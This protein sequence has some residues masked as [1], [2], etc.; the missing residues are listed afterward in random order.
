MEKLKQLL[1]KKEARRKELANKGKT[2]ESVAELRSI[3]SELDDLNTEIE[4][5]RSAIA[6]G[7]N[8]A[9]ETRSENPQ[10]PIGATTI[11]GIYGAEQRNSPENAEAEKRQ[12]EEEAAEKRGQDLYERRA[13]MVSSDPLI[14]PHHD[15]ATIN[16]SF[17]QVS[18]LIDR[19]RMTPLQGGESYDVPF[20]IQHGEGNYTAEGEPYFK[21]DHEFGYARIHKTKVTAYNEITEEVLK[22]PRA[23]YGSRVQ[24]GINNSMR[25]KITREILRGSGQSGE[26]VGIFS[27]M[28][29]AINPATD[30]EIS[31]INRD[32]LDDIIFA[33]GGE[34][35]VE[36]PSV[37]MLSKSDL[38]KFAMV[39]DEN[40]RK[41]YDIVTSGNTGTINAVQFIINSGAGSLD[42]SVSGD[43]LMAYGPLENYEMAIFSD[44]EILRSDDYKFREG[45]IAHRGSV[46]SG[47]N[48]VS[49]NGFLRIKKA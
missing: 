38:R 35:D 40:G 14:T 48:V 6:E 2:T 8:V 12:Q 43:Y 16:D 7:E 32:T 47:G 29:T 45:I 26:F 4:E 31:E 13:I 22:L 42:R 30:I 39:R 19:V 25:R 44:T 41:Y 46:F 28:A 17:N 24:A 27:P 5:L 15:N 1:K 10:Q 23:D 11:M 20:E 21:V 9:P 37:L 3:N 49:F 34:E 36:G 33:F 18:S